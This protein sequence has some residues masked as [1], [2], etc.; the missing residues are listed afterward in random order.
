MKAKSIIAFLILLV[1]GSPIIVTAQTETGTIAGVVTD[2]TGAVVP[3]ATITATSVDRH[4][5]RSATAGGK[6]EYIITNLEP[7]TYEVVVAGT[8]FGTFKQRVQVTVGGRQ[9]V[10][11][12]LAVAG[13]G[14]TVEVLAEGAAQ[15]NTEDQSISQVVTGTQVRELPTITRNPYDLVALSGNVASAESSTNANNTR[16]VGGFNMNGQRATSTNILLD[17]G[18]NVDEF[19]ANLGATVPLDSVHEFRVLTSNYTAEYGRASGGVVNVATRSGTNSFH[20]SLYEFNRISEF[21]ANSYQNNATGLPRDH[22]VRNQFGYAI[23]GPIVRD[24][25]FFFQSTEWRR[26]RGD[27]NNQAYIPTP[28]LLAATPANTRSF[29]NQLGKLR[30]DNRPGGTLTRA[31]VVAAPTPGSPLGLIAPG[32]PVLQLVNY[33][34]AQDSGGGDPQNTYFGVVRVDYNITNNTQLFGRYAADH[35]TFFPGFVST[36]PYAGFETTQKTFNQNVILNLTH[37]FSANVISQSKLAYNRFNLFQPLGTAGVVPGMAP[38]GSVPVQVSG[39]GIN[40]LFPGYLPLTPSNALP[41]GGPQNLYQIYQDFS[42]HRGAHAFKFGGEY[43]QTRDNRTFGAFQT[44]FYTLARNGSVPSSLESLLTG[45]VFQFQGAVNPKGAFPCVVNPVTNAPIVT[46]SCTISLP[47]SPPQFSRNNRFN[48]GA[49]YA[50]DTWKV[51]PRVTLNLGVRWEYYGVQHNGNE[52]L[53]SN[54]YFGPGATPFQ[55][56]TNGFVATT[57]TLPPHNLWEPRWQNFAPR[58]GFAIDPFGT[59]RT[60]LRGGYGMAYERNFGNVTFNVIQN[61]PNYGVVSLRSPGDI[62]TPIPI[63]TSN[64][65][66]LGAPSGTAPLLRTSLRAVDPH[67]NTAYAHF[68]SMAFEHEVVRNTVFALEYS[69]S[70][71]V[72][73]YSISDINALG[74]GVVFG[75]LNPAVVVP[76]TRLQKQYSNI[77]FRGSNGDSYYNGLNVRVASTN[78]QNVGL[79]LTANYT[80]AHS[81]DNL[82]STFSESSNNFNL[83][84]LNPFNPR[85]DRGNSDYDVRHRFVFSALYQVPF[86]D[87]KGWMRQALGGWEVAPIFNAQTGTPFS[88]W[89]STNSVELTPR[90]APLGAALPPLSGSGSPPTTAPN[91]FAYLTLPAANNFNNAVLG[92]SD[93]GPFPA[94]MTRRNEFRGPNHWWLDLG[95]DKNF[96][97][98]ER[99]GLQLRGEAFNLPNHANLWVLGSSADV[100]SSQ[101]VQAKKGG[102]AGVLSTATNTHEHR[103]MQLAI[104]LNF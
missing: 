68:Y 84:Y 16:G 87:K 24:R 42:V 56:I 63:S 49:I 76:T 25:L 1:I 13:T 29:F 59:G 53:D 92:F 55:R 27:V 98:T 97:L 9:T 48:D 61:P 60:S 31:Q 72:H 69:G 17:G 22:F 6:G 78:F 38:R 65:G 21:A 37:A 8:G 45:T 43:I 50:Q 99:V 101:I 93:F 51:L 80:W 28:Q 36:S 54:F 30:L 7:G 46:P 66:P 52:S 100:G 2:P 79:S 33:S 41:F 102:I 18:Q 77:N 81:I 82:S 104:K 95:V 71:G 23:G 20:G 44:G 89:D 5:S 35:D 85:L 26:V 47:V 74:T 96:K 10:N 19:N 12:Q 58:V 91:A 88:V 62:S 67:I 4:N 83:G 70:R 39:T 57:P 75:G 64:F 103:N 11:A 86:P 14:T 15:V 3:G 90:Y 34:T 94:N 32:T 40:L 73:Q